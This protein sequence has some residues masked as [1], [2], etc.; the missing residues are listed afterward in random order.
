VNDRFQA[1]WQGGKFQALDE[2]LVAF[3]GHTKF[4]IH[5]PNKP[6]KWGIRFFMLCDSEMYYCRQ[7]VIDTRL[8]LSMP[9]LFDLFNLTKG[10]V[11]FTD[12]YY[13]TT[14]LA[15]SLI[16][17]G[18]GLVGTTQ[19]NR[20]PVKELVAAFPKGTK[21]QRERGSYE[22]YTTA[23]DDI[24]YVAWMDTK[25]VFFTCTYGSA[26]EVVVQRR[27]RTGALVDVKAP[28]VVKLFC[29]NM[30]G[31]DTNN[32]LCSEHYSTVNDQLTR[33]WTNK[34]VFAI[35]DIICANSWIIYRHYHANSCKS[36]F[37]RDLFKALLTHDPYEDL[38]GDDADD[39]K[40]R[41]Q[42]LHHISYLERNAKGRHKNAQC[43]QCGGKSQTESGCII[44]RAALH[45]K[46]FH[47][48][49][50][51]DMKR[52]GRKVTLRFEDDPK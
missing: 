44:C 13:T 34:C 20:F 27:Q 32:H 28:K 2:K 8:S 9:E 12:R 40:I 19:V 42:S 26:S 25:P 29:D 21:K 50:C 22:V 51:G 37:Y 39:A 10:Q 1:H 30:G 38:G 5:M 15:T 46:C 6:K 49:H 52:K 11:L 17:R 33:K 43:W 47:L 45:V 31:V 24:A 16:K 48:W 36:A 35:L 3:K 14:A 41:S 4:R 18:I 23:N 7:F